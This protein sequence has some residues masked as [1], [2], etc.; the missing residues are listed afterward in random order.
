MRILREGDPGEGLCSKCRR[1]VAI[2]YTYRT[3]NLERSEVDV[4]DVLVGVCQ[5]CGETVSIP[6]QSTPKLKEARQEKTVVLNVRIPHHLDDVLRMLADRFEAPP[7]S[8]CSGLVRFY[9]HELAENE[10]FAR[11]IKR[12]GESDL[13]SGPAATRLSVRTSQGLA[14]AAWARA[15]KVGIRTRTEMLK[16]LILAAYE[17]VLQGRAPRRAEVLEGIAAAA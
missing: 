9:L 10:A 3:V 14:T 16:G 8:F 17:D 2:R 6:A 13:A 4:P 11:R 15:R 1:R 7:W 5:T 12:L